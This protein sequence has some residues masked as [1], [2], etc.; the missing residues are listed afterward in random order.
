[1]HR[2]FTTILSLLLSMPC[3]FAQ[4]PHIEKSE[5]FDEPDDGYNK[6]LMM[7]NGNTFFFHFAHKEGIEIDVYSK[8][9]KLVGTKEI[10]SDLWD[11]KKMKNITVAGLY[12]IN[13]EA[14]LFVVDAAGRTPTLYRLR[15]NGTTGAKIKEEEIGSSSKSK[16]FTLVRETN[17]IFVEKDPESDCYAVIFFNGFSKDPDDKIKVMHFDGNHK[18]LSTVPYDSPDDNF[19]YLRYI[20]AVVDGDKR[21]FIST[22]GAASLNGNE[23]RVFI[24]SLKA[25]DK[26]FV[27]KALEFTEDFKETKSVMLYNHGNNSL[28]LLTLSYA[29]GQVSF[30]GNATKTTYLSFMAYIDPESLDLKS[31]KPIAGQKI[32]EYAH[33]VLNTDLNYKGLPQNMIINKDNSTTILSEEMSWKITRE[34][35]RAGTIVHYYT[36]MGG[37]GANELNADGTEKSGYWIRKQQE[38]G[39]LIEPLYISSR[40]KGR[41]NYLDG[42]AEH[43]SYMSYDY[44]NT[45]NNRYIIFNDDDKNFDKDEDEKKRKVVVKVNKLNTICYSLNGT[46]INKS[47]LFGEP[48]DG[49]SNSLHIDAS[50]FDKASGTYATIMVERDG[51]DRSAKLVWIKFD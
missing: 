42:H 23:G 51:R 12:E 18:K 47:F 33:T 19:K 44:I 31:V 32:N 14:V 43:N 24:S 21:I 7:K 4:G 15:I 35:T 8:E 36:F 16:V 5:P 10:S 25:G 34:Q 38:A 41:W 11:T 37:I 48:G 27:N 9:R 49:V 50:D 46:G 3:L 20:G 17:S 26:K 2:V 40:T 28:Q 30:F 6:V 39:G 22:Y 45:D 29:R 13:K 1:M